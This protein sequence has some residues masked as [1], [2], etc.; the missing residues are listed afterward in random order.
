MLFFRLREFINRPLAAL[1]C[2]FVVQAAPLI[3]FAADQ[4]AEMV[5]EQSPHR[6]ETCEQVL[7][8]AADRYFKF[9]NR[10]QKPIKLKISA[11]NQT[12]AQFLLKANSY[13][14]KHP[15]V[16]HLVKRLNARLAK[17]ITQPHQQLAAW[18]DFIHVQ[19]NKVKDFSQGLDRLKEIFNKRYVT[20][21]SNVPEEFFTLQ[22]RINR[23]MGRGELL[24][25]PE[26]R[27]HLVDVAL[28]E[29]IESL[30]L[31][32]DYFFDA[33][34][35]NYPMWV[36]YWA[37]TNIVKLG[38]Y[39]PDTNTFA[40]RSNSFMGPF[41]EVNR[42]AFPIVADAILLK[43]NKGDLSKLDTGI[44]EILKSG[45]NFSRL[46]ARAIKISQ[47]Q[48]A[49]LSITDGR[50]ILYKQG[51]NPARL[52]QDLRGKNT[53]WCS[54]NIAKAGDQLYEGDLHVYYSHD[55]NGS[56]T[57]PRAAIYVQDH[58]IIEVRGR[59]AQQNADPVL[60]GSDVLKDK[61]KKFGIEGHAYLKSIGH[62]Q[63]LTQISSKDAKGEELS[64]KE[65]RF[66]YEIDGKI[67]G[68]GYLPDPRIKE[69]L[70]KR[71]AETK[72]ADLARILDIRED[73]VSFTREEALSGKAIVHF[74]DLD[75]SDIRSAHGQILPRYILGN[76][77][78]RRLESAA[79]L[80]MPERVRTLDLRSLESPNGLVLPERAD[81]IRLGSLKRADRLVFPDE[82]E[83]L[84]LNSLETAVGMVLPK[85]VF[86]LR[87]A[88][89]ER[90]DGLVLPEEIE[91]LY[92]NS[93]R[94]VKGLVFANN[95]EELDL[96]SLRSTDYLVLPEILEILHI[97]RHLVD[98]IKDLRPDV[99]VEPST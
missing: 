76:L 67:E 53:G 11:E 16:R 96:G 14:A 74:G 61:L 8:S 45:G 84:D 95:I 18:F 34:T 65:L 35:E 97:S 47:S 42:E 70:D 88:S 78:L 13:L 91:K 1:F 48:V 85:R 81:I 71:S 25:T 72:R 6:G 36:K 50:W 54:T 10:I 60:S 90:P 59:G 98:E 41:E 83:S 93:L 24:L 40:V 32:I 27:D 44:Q 79:G 7:S 66:L 2:L 5:G 89:L 26:K 30:D 23:E 46:Y 69:I 37:F 87:M 75:L 22:K 51:S 31:W 82:M 33:D 92:L 49:D 63:Y 80:A 4:T 56:A 94:S 19:N 20:K 68:F 17:P 28:G 38:K 52:V 3:G 12:G 86:V 55:K 9:S 99:V 62:M 39:D 21:R 73:Q 15:H 29:Q 43:A 77:D 64:D 57:V 58:R